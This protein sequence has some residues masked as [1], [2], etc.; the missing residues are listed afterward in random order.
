MLLL[1]SKHNVS[2]DLAILKLFSMDAS[3]KF[4]TSSDH[5][6]NKFF[7]LLQIIYISLLWILFYLFSLKNFS[8]FT[9]LQQLLWWQMPH[10]CKHFPFKFLVHNFLVSR[11]QGNRLADCHK[12]HIEKT[13][14][15][16][17]KMRLTMIFSLIKTNLPNGNKWS[18]TFS[19][20]LSQVLWC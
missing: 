11:F 2:L 1:F 13:M 3:M 15:S 20:K 6:G 18:H 8:P 17:L 4:L 9:L 5:H 12:Y 7:N 14:L 19:R 10:H 16:F